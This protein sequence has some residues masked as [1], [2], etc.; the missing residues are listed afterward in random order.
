MSVEILKFVPKDSISDIISNAFSEAKLSGYEVIIFDTA[1]RISIDKKL[2]EEI[3]EIHNLTKPIE[4]LLVLD[5]MTGQDSIN[6]AKSFASYLDI[7]GTILTRIDGDARGGAALSM[8]HVTGKPIK[9]LGTGEKP[10]SFEVFSAVRVA[11]RILDMGDIV[12][13]VEKAEEEIDEE[14]AKKMA[15]KISKGEFTLDDFSSQLK[16]MKK[17][18]GMKSILSML[19]GVKKAKNILNNAN[20]DDGHFIRLSAIISSMTLVERRNTK[21]INGSRK[22]R[23]AQGS[24]TEIYEVNR[25]LKQFKGMQVM[26]KKMNKPGSSKMLNMLAGSNNN[27]INKQDIFK[28]LK[29]FN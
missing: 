22:K 6:I 2:M 5:A 27:F 18:G 1:G 11:N 17:L 15:A 26:M 14:E 19:P 10:D 29:N 24:G 21:I 16:Q 3:K 28:S 25:L 9:Y 8:R 12:G 23:I 4:T 20:L 7:T 13:I